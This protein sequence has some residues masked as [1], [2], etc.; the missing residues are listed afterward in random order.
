[1]VAH[2]IRICQ[3]IV[4]VGGAAGAGTH[5]HRSVRIIDQI[6]VGRR[7]VILL[8]IG[9]DILAAQPGACFLPHGSGKRL[10]GEYPA[11]AYRAE[12][13]CQKPFQA[14]LFIFTIEILAFLYLV[15]IQKDSFTRCPPVH[16]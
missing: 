10:G 1:M 16:H 12:Q 5:I 4:P 9:A 11:E 7:A 3:H 8:P 6:G 13:K 15:G 14:V 2:P